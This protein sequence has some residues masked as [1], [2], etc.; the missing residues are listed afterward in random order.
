MEIPISVHCHDDFGLAVANSLS[1]V[2][3]GA[4][5]VH[6]TINGLGER[7]G[8]TSLEEV[9]MALMINYGIKTNI[10]TELLVGTSELVSRITG[11]KMPPNKA[12]VGDNAFAHEAGIHVHGVLQKAETYEPLKPEM[13]G[14]TRRIIMGKH[15]GTRAI[16]SKLDDYGIE[17]DEDQF[18][19]LYD[20]VKKLGDK[21]KM[22]T[23]ADLQALAET[24]IG[25]PKE[26]KVKLEGF[27]V[28]TGDNVLPTATVK[29]NIDGNIKTSAQT[30]VGPVDAAI[31]AIQ[32]LVRET[33][34]I[35]L[36]EYHIEAI[37][38]GTNALAEVFVIL[39]DKEGNSATGRSTVE[40]VVM[41]SV[42]AVLDA[43]NKILIG[44]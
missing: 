2:E 4:Q 21:G 3:A 28:I 38:G 15:T 13:V 40:D 7:A 31:N 11:V 17:L 10:N 5:Q 6:A 12:I 37:T 22:V 42:E 36:K 27:T 24:V 18:C 44:R 1:A 29:L 35:K 23:D 34:D 26:E 20:Q 32:S 33:T 25:R 9:V 16:R 39:A 30:G 19:S 8:N 43:I 14:H 41:A